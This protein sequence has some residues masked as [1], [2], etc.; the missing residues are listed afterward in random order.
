MDYTNICG[1]ILEACRAIERLG[2]VYGTWGNISV[3]HENGLIMTPSRISYDVMK[4]GDMVYM[5]FDGNI[6]K[7]HQIPTSERDIHRLIL[8]KRPDLGAVVHTHSPHACAA[9]AAGLGL[10]ALIE[11][12]A[13]LIGGAVPVTPRYIPGGNHLELANLAVET[14]GEVNAVLIKN[15]GP[16]SCGA[17]LGEALICAQVTEKAAQMALMLPSPG[18]FA[19]PGEYVKEERER[20]LHRYGKE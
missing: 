10:P 12:I 8:K 6:I 1:Q 17:N 18:D 9:A 19:I 20:F 2:L 4:P 7:G 5:D 11:E 16:V 15:H 14:L 13:Q 3:R